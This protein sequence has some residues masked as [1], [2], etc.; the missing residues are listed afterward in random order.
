MCLKL[1]Q[2]KFMVFCF[3]HQREEADEEGTGTHGETTATR[4]AAHFLVVRT[5]RFN[6]LQRTFRNGIEKSSIK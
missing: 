2:R 4:F 3:A 5:I 1:V 6:T